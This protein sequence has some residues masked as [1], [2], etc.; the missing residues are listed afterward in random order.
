MKFAYFA[1]LLALIPLAAC[2]IAPPAVGVE[3]QAYPA[4]IIPGIHVQVPLDEYGSLTGRFAAN[5]TD[6]QD[7]GEFDNEE[8]E[9]FGGGIGYRRYLETGQTGWL[10]GGRIDIWSLEIDFE[11]SGGPTGTSDIIVLQ[12]TAE[13]GYGFRLGEGSW[14]L[15]VALGV[16]AEIN[17]DTDGEDVG[18]GAIVLLGVTLL[19]R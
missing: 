12:P 11:D 6:R 10:Y 9:G 19:N 2:S 16:G 8:G 1:A 17:V 15:E 3:F 14:R 5:I 18:E 13:V 4:G 7:F